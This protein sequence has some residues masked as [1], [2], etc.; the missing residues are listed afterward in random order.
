MPIYRYCGKAPAIHET[1]FVA[2]GAII[3]GDIQLAAEVSVWFNATIRCDS[4]PIHVGTR[5]NVQEGAVLHADPGYPLVIE[6]DVTIGHQAMLHGCTIGAGS[7]IGIQ[8][9]ILNGARIGKHCLVGAGAVVTE[10]KEFPDGSLIL[11]SPAK[12]V[13]ALSEEEMQG[14][15]SSAR[16]YA[17]KAIVAKNS[18]EAF[19]LVSSAAP[20]IG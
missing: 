13:R 5:S 10:H 15:L 8:A 4:E 11:G 9:V 6:E 18:L 19:D 1:V 17:E 16:S 12:I 20:P 3:A 2:P 7:L 14:L